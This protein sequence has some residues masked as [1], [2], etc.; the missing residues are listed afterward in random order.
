MLPKMSLPLHWC[1]TN[2]VWH[3]KIKLDRLYSLL[4]FVLRIWTSLT[5]FTLFMVVWFLGQNNFCYCPSS[6]LKNWHLLQKWSKMTQKIISIHKS[7]SVTHF[8]CVPWLYQCTTTMCRFTFCRGRISA[9]CCFAWGL[10]S[11]FTFWFGRL[12]SKA[13]EKKRGERANWKC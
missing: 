9:K 10:H 1:K 8:V 4:Q 6:C 3:S 5:W 13:K 2:Y 7:K 11:F 12:I